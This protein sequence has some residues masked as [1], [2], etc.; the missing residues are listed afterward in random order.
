MK[1]SEVSASHVSRRRFLH[2]VAA[3][4]AA[5]H[6]VPGSALGLNGATAA[7]DRL[8]VAA[9]GAGGQ[10]GGDVRQFEKENVVALCDADWRRAAGT[11]RHFPKAKQF[12]DFR[13]MLDKMGRDIDAVIVATPDQNGKMM[14]REW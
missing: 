4:T 14:I 12:R 5:F 3:T 13:Q 9:I 1:K 8:N 7:N 10:G 2:G 11:F 6:V